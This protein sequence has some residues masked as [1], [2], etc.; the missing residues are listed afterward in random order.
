LKLK[1]IVAVAVLVLPAVGG[2]VVASP[3]LA[4]CPSNTFCLY[5][6]AGYRGT[7]ARFA[8]GDS[9]AGVGGIDNDA[10]AMR[11]YRDNYIRMW[12]FPGCVGTLTY[13]ADP[14]SYDSDFDNNH[15]TNKASS[16]KRI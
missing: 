5:S 6:G 9:C 7:E 16:L 14:L 11:N 10:N 15:F 13:T 12:D 2:V 1:T 3:A 8:P 4:D